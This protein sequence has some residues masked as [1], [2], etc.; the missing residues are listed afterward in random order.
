MKTLLFLLSV[1]VSLFTFGQIDSIHFSEYKYVSMI[2]LIATPEKYQDKKVMVDGYINIEF[3]GTA[4]YLHEE[5]Y[6]N[7]ITKNSISINFLDGF[8]EKNKINTQDYTQKHVIISGIFKNNESC[9]Y[10]GM[11]KATSIR[12]L[13]FK[14]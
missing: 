8:F 6:K 4:L 9:M 1:N 12:L 2:N 7:G 11:I 14:E 10:S 3:E 5:D 13:P